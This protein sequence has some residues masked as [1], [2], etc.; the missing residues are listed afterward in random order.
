MK[1]ILPLRLLWLN[2]AH[3]RLLGLR[4]SVNIC[5]PTASECFS[6][7]VYSFNRF[8]SALQPK[9]RQTKPVFQARPPCSSQRTAKYVCVCVYTSAGH[10][11][12]QHGTMCGTGMGSKS[13]KTTDNVVVCFIN[14]QSKFSLMLP[15]SRT[16]RNNTYTHPTHT[17]KDD[18]G[19]KKK[20]CSQTITRIEGVS[21]HITQIHADRIAR[22]LGLGASPFVLIPA[23]GAECVVFSRHI[24]FPS[25]FHHFQRT[26]FPYPLKSRKSLPH[27]GKRARH[28]GSSGT[29][30]AL[31]FSRVHLYYLWFLWPF[32]IKHPWNVMF[33]RQVAV[34]VVH[35]ATWVAVPFSD[36]SEKKNKKESRWMNLQRPK[37]YGCVPLNSARTAWKVR[38]DVG[39]AFG[40]TAQRKGTTKTRAKTHITLNV[41]QLQRRQFLKWGETHIQFTLE[42]MGRVCVTAAQRPCHSQG[43]L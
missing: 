38:P 29:L 4:S 20:H 6:A 21:R 10:M 42:Q 23:G 28:T 2:A 1:F 35:G 16:M 15:W 8:Q 5:L 11:Q 40:S 24:S 30:V 25:G 37:L 27:R 32:E 41:K 26:F 18:G 43:L 12:H 33:C 7:I 36:G 34:V 14:Y 19:R 13:T 9:S 17:P 3:F 31:L 39:V 22:A